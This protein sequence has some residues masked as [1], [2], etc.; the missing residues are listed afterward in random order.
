MQV[1]SKGDAVTRRK[2]ETTARM[3]ER[4]FPHI[5]ELPLPSG[6]FRERSADIAGFH[7]DR[8]IE[9]RRGRGRVDEGQW[10]VRYCFADPAHADAF[11]E[12]FGGERLTA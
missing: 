7:S 8:G 1:R 2:G 6:G 5:V 12:R 3:I 10:Y 11:C 9:P 4:A